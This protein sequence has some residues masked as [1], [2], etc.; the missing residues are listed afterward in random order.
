[1]DELTKGD[2]E[3]GSSYVVVA[4]K[5]Q[6]NAMKLM[7]NED[8]LV[9]MNITLQNELIRKFISPQRFRFVL[10]ALT[11]G[12]MVQKNNLQKTLLVKKEQATMKKLK[13]MQKPTAAQIDKK[14]DARFK[15]KFVVLCQLQCETF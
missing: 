15:R 9:L 7:T 14:V 3:K 1:M 5:A 4:L 11:K 6:K 12:G 10:I 2:K 13:K 8:Y